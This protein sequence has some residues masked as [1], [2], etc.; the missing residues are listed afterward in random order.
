MQTSKMGIEKLERSDSVVETQEKCESGESRA[1]RGE[2]LNYRP[3]M[4][5]REG[6]GEDRR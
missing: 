2:P 1:W 3:V 5:R 6:A 4:D